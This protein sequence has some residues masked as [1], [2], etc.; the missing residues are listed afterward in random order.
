MDILSGL[1]GIGAGITQGAKDRVAFQQADQ[2]AALT[3]FNI[4]KMA[5]EEKTLNTRV[6]LSAIFPGYEKYPETTRFM[7]DAF[8]AAGQEADWT[9]GQI[10][11][12]SLRGAKT[13]MEMM[14]GK[15][16]MLK[17]FNNSMR[18]DILMQH[19]DVSTQLATGVDKEGKKLNDK[20]LQALQSE[21][22]KLAKLFTATEELEQHIPLMKAKMSQD[23]TMEKRTYFGTDSSGK[24]IDQ[25]GRGRLYYSGTDTPFTGD[26]SGLTPKAEN[27][28]A[29]PT[30]ST[31]IR[32]GGNEADHRSTTEKEYERWKKDPGNEKKTYGEFLTFKAGLSKKTDDS[33]D[34]GNLTGPKKK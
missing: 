27:T 26:T 31:V 21:Q 34:F 2:N 16:E 32:V 29:T 25:D 11:S 5:Q 17:H 10:P 18:N 24:Q 19:K 30:T 14:K 9:D 6:P 22:S 28:R 23:K 3:Q 7:K 4:N 8:K 13:V 1:G 33:I 15:D 12:I 20:A